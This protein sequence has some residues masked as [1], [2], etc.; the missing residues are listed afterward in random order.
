[1][2][3]YE[4][5]G[6]TIEEIKEKAIKDLG[7]TEEDIIIKITETEESGL[8]KSKK[9]KA[10][11]LLKDEVV[12]YIKT[13]LTGICEKMGIEVNI[14][15][16][17][18]DK[19]IKLNL[20]SNNNAVLIGKGGRTIEA[21]QKITKHSILNNTGFYIN[22]VIDVEDYKEKQQR[23]IEREAK[24]IAREVAVSGVEAKMDCMNSFERRL[25]HE[26]ISSIEGVT[27]IS[28]GEEPN[29]YIIIKL[30]K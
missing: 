29:R 16:K 5:E 15:C 6:K 24:T 7:K 13:F 8:F 22:L 27:T 19:L 11:V 25:V 28:E 10:S 23:N 21:L 2:R 30:E 18:R 4:Y 14:E 9:E 12:D 3:V 17:K 20:F 1:M 26:I